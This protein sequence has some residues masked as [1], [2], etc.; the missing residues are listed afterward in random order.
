MNKLLKILALSLFVSACGYTQNSAD[1]RIMNTRHQ[2][3]DTGHYP[4]AKTEE[5]WRKQ[6]TPEQF[7]IL[8]QAGTEKP[9]T[10]QYFDNKKPGIYYSAASGQPLFVSDAK[11]DSGCGWPSFFEP[12][13]PGAVFYRTDSAHGMLR[14]E[15]I[16]SGSG[17]HLGHVFND[18]PPPTGLR[19]CMNSAAMVFVGLGDTA[20]DLVRQYMEHHATEQEKQAVER[21][22]A[23]WK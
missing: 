19:Y 23:I 10:G 22:L 1:M 12:I 21:F 4:V 7:E 2:D 5:S 9:F 15:V 11:Y 14:T 8:R 18:G 16:D 6:L 13:V 17:S 3:T 20:P